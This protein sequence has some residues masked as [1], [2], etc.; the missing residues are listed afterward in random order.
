MAQ[1][2]SN[3]PRGGFGRRGRLDLD[4]PKA[5]LNKENL[6]EAAVLFAYLKPYRGWLAAVCVGLC[7]SGAMGLSF[8]YL[9]G[10]LVDA[11]TPGGLSHRPPWLPQHINTIAGLMFVMMAVQACAMF[12]N[13]TTMTRVG[14]SAVA[15][16]R[17][18][19]YGRIICLPMAFF[20]QRRVGELNSRLSADLTQIEATLIMSVPQF[21][22]QSLMLIGGIALIAVTSGR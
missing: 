19:T 14:Q 8:P 21:I 12:F 9:A 4:L 17:R 5:K 7:V 11:A 13:S 2:N 6:R 10:S 3:G 20:G 22:R 1:N 16:L 15:N 18:D